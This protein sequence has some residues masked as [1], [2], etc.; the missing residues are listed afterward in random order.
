MARESPSRAI[1]F[2]DKVDSLCRNES[3]S[4]NDR[5]MKSEFLI[6]MD[7]V[8]KKDNVFVLGATNRPWE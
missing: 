2:I 1:I 3:E 8:G 7:G 4:G 5:Q 6:Q